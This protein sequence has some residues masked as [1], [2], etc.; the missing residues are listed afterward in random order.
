MIHRLRPDALAVTV[1]LRRQVATYGMIWR[2][3]H[4]SST[5]IG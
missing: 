2:P 3:S 1:I 5:T 4:K